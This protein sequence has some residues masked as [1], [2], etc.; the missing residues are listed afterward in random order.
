MT[1]TVQLVL[2]SLTPWLTWLYAT[3][4]R[5]TLLLAVAWWGMRVA[6]K[7][8]A[9]FRAA[10][11]AVPILAV[12]MLFGARHLPVSWTA[13]LLPR[14]LA[15]P[16]VELQSARVVALTAQASPSAPD[17]APARY[18]ARAVVVLLIA[19]VWLLG[20]V[21]TVW[22]LVGGSLALRRLSRRSAAI[23]DAGWERLVEEARHDLGVRRVVRLL[24]DAGTRSPITWGTLRPTILLPVDADGW[25]EELRRAVILHEMEHVRAADTLFRVITRLACAVFWFHPLI[26]WAGRQHA[27]LREQACDDVA[28][29]SG[30]AASTYAEFLVRVAAAPSPTPAL[31][32]VAASAGSSARQLRDRVIAAVDRDRSRRPLRR[33]SAVLLGLTSACIAAILGTSR[34]APTSG[35]ALRL[36]QHP[37]W[38]TRAYAVAALPDASNPRVR[39]ALSVAMTSDPSEKVRAFARDLL[40]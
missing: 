40:H 1:P 39:R 25:P 11:C 34:L 15:M 9:A 16:V 2:L 18:H 19:S 13:D 4:L 28:L 27:V 5:L 38:E 7:C 35:A 31:E 8:S 32:S 20:A 12:L 30:V 33:S 21:A 3:A 24:K 10:L 26:W 17:L 14:S 6:A 29:R 22:P 36:L 23:V 37:R